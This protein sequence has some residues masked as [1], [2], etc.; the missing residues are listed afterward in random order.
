MKL[1]LVLNIYEIKIAN[2][3]VYIFFYQQ[4]SDIY[5]V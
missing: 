1:F 2:K 3:Q 4:S 5:L